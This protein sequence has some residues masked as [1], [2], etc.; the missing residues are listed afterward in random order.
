VGRGIPIRRIFDST[1]STVN[2]KGGR[3]YGE[4]DGGITAVGSSWGS[5]QS[6][7]VFHIENRVAYMGGGRGMKLGWGGGSERGKERGF[8]NRLIAK[9]NYILG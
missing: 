1:E 3:S 2:I 5:A 9:R 7:R 6:E 8:R 4:R